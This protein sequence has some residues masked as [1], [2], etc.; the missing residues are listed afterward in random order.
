MPR[1]SVGLSAFRDKTGDRIL[2]RCSASSML[3]I[4]L[5]LSASQMDSGW[6]S[7]ST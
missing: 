6:D 2:L 3:A 5:C 1:W 7:V 4:D